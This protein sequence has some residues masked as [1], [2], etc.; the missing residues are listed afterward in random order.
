MLPPC[1]PG[2]YSFRDTYARL[3]FVGNSLSYALLRRSSSSHTDL[4]ILPL[5]PKEWH[6]Y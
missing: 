6:Y 3:T 4:L 5:T 2:L 1:T